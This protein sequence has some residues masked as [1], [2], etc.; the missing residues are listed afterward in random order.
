MHFGYL[1]AG[2]VK[3]P[4]FVQTL[5]RLTGMDI[6]IV[7]SIRLVQF[8]Y[9]DEYVLWPP[10]SAYRIKDANDFDVNRFLAILQPRVS[11]AFSNL[12]GCVILVALANRDHVIF[13]Q[14]LRWLFGNLEVQLA[15]RG[16]L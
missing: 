13:R 11:I 9:V 7:E 15:P 1:K 16:F 12:G 4:G 3:I 14:I 10:E 2:S 8:R 5:L 6:S